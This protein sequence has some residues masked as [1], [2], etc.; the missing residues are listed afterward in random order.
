MMS[1][2]LALTLVMTACLLMTVV[3]LD[4]L[5]C[6]GARHPD[7]R[8]WLLC[9][10]ALASPISLLAGMGISMAAPHLPYDL[11]PAQARNALTLSAL[12][13]VL[14]GAFAAPISWRVLVLCRLRRESE[15]LPFFRA[16]R[17]QLL[18]LFA[19]AVIYMWVRGRHGGGPWLT[20][21]ELNY[22]QLVAGLMAGLIHLFLAMVV[23]TLPL[24]A[25]RALVR[26]AVQ[27]AWARV[28]LAARG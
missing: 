17:A 24:M 14:I 15:S 28:R 26:G 7:G 22:V 19:L 21:L 23:I 27:A 20:T 11:L 13:L 8:H 1:G 18:A 25:L 2:Y 5:H 3:G 16:T 12:P 4:V 10:L 6:I 9:T